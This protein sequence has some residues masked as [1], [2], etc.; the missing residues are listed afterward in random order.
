MMSFTESKHWVR[1]GTLYSRD[2]TRYPY[3]LSGGYNWD[4]GDV[5]FGGG[6]DLE[7]HCVDRGYDI[8]LETGEI[9]E[10]W[11]EK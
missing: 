4:L 10:L 9:E 2:G 1:I 3:C 8:N 5:A 7:G 6:S 11:F